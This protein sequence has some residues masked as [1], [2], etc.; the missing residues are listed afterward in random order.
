M[1]KEQFKGA[2]KRNWQKVVVVGVGVATIGSAVGCEGKTLTNNY[3]LTIPAINQPA[4]QTPAAVSQDG[5]TITININGSGATASSGE[6]GGEKVV[7]PTT[8]TTVS[9]TVTSTVEPTT[10]PTTPDDP[11]LK[12]YGNSIVVGKMGSV[13]ITSPT[14][15][16]GDLWVGGHRDYDDD[17]TT[18]SI[19]VA[20]VGGIE[21]KST[22][23]TWGGSGRTNLSL[24][25][26]D[27][28]TRQQALITFSQN[29]TI[30]K[31]FVYDAVTGVQNPTPFLRS[32][33]AKYLN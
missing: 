10:T 5:K 12:E 32:D 29:P 31:I 19:E 4:E 1:N 20:R 21:F 23:P 14:V 33:F 6:S 22:S 18:G 15:I 3:N 17:G 9:P 7:V 24:D 27:V 30:T 11:L 28:A 2:I 26:L 16:S 8:E 25:Q 13:V